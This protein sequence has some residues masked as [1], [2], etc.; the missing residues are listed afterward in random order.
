MSILSTFKNIIKAKLKRILIPRH[1][2]ICSL[3]LG[4]EVDNIS[5][6]IK[7]F[8]NYGAKNNPYILVH[9]DEL[10]SDIITT[11]HINKT[12]FSKVLYERDIVDSNIDKKYGYSRGYTCYEN[13]DHDCK[14]FYNNP[15]ELNKLFAECHFEEIYLTKIKII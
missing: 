14:R 12:I 2:N 10:E 11:N 6:E 5:G 4:G 3:S 9:I 13:K 7:S 8:I 1:E 15:A